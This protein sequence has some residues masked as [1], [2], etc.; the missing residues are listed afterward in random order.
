MDRE[1][2][3]L[4]PARKYI[5]EELKDS[6]RGAL[7]ADM[8]AMRSGDFESVRTKKLRAK[9]YELISGNHRITYFQLKRNLYFVRGFRKK[10]NRTPKKE[11]EY[12]E[13][14]YR[15]TNK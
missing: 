11:I 10:T 12:A 5:Q 1:V 3:I 14:I 7:Q 8:E 13:K 9:V 2:K 6:E 15:I 4:R